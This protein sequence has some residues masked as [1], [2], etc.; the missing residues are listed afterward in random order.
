[1]TDGKHWFNEQITVYEREATLTFELTSCNFPI[2]NLN[3]SYTLAT[4]EGQTTVT[5]VMTYTPRFGVLGKL[6]DAVAMR[7]RSD[8]GIKKFLAGLKAHVEPSERGTPRPKEH[9][10]DAVTAELYGNEL[11]AGDGH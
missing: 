10:P 3:H 5:Q 8:A 9:D 2:K 1:M 6:M 4:N 11:G 7:K